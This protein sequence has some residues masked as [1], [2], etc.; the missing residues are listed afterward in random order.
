MLIQPWLAGPPPDREPPRIEITRPSEGDVLEEHDVLV[1]WTVDD[2]VAGVREVEL[3]LDGG[4]PINVTGLT[5]YTLEDVPYGRHTLVLRAVD[6]AGRVAETSRS[7]EI[8][9][10]TEVLSPA[11][12]SISAGLATSGLIATASLLWLRKRRH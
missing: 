10:I 5:N 9:P 4:E 6:W 2:D 12:I 7:F 3:I 1:E 11:G 8:R